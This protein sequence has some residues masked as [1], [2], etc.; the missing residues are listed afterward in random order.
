[1]H[2]IRLD[3]D[4][5]TCGKCTARVERALH[6][7]GIAQ[8]IE[9]ALD[10][11]HA[12]I[13]T[14][15]EHDATRAQLIEAIEDAGY[16]V[17]ERPEP[18]PQS[19]PMAPEERPSDQS[20]VQENQLD[21]SG[22]VVDV[23][24][25]TCASCV[26]RVERALSSLPQ[27]DHVAVNYATESA[28]LRW[29]PD[30]PFEPE[31]E[32]AIRDAVEGAG[33]SVHDVR[34]PHDTTRVASPSAEPPSR[35][36]PSARRAEEAARWRRRWV[37]GLVLTPAI[38][39]LQ[40]GPMMAD[41]SLGVAANAGRLVLCAYLT[42]VVAVAA[43]APFFVGAWRAARH[44]TATMDT[45]VALGAGV[46]Y[47]ASLVVTIA[48]IAGNVWALGAE[49][50]FDGAAMI[51]TLIGVG[52]WLEARA[53][54][55][56][57]H[58]IEALMQ[59]G[60]RRARVQRGD[61]WVEIDARE[62]RVGDILLVRPGETIPTD[63]VITQGRADVD[64]S[65][66]TGEPV[67]VA[68]EVGDEVAGATINTDGRL[69]VRAVRT[70]SDTLI[71]R[72]AREVERAQT[73]RAEI[74]R[75]ADR[76]SAI[77]V[78]AVLIASLVTFV[79]W[80]IATGV[81]SA[82]LLPAVAV[83]VV[84][85]PCAL[86]LATPTA[87]MV[88]TGRAAQQ[89]VLIRAASA[90]E[91][92]SRLDALV[93]DKTGTLTTG[94]MHVTDRIATTLEI[95]A[96]AMLQIVAS[97]EAHS[98]HPVAAAIATEAAE[99]GI[100]LLPITDFRA[101]AGHGVTATV[102]GAPI[103]IGKIEWM[104]E[105]AAID[106]DT[107][108][109]VRAL[110][111]QTRT[112]V[113]A[114]RAGQLIGIIATTDLVREGAREVITWLHDRHVQVWM[115]TGDAEATA[116]SVASALGIDPAHVRAGVAP[117]D[118]AAAVRGI[119]QG[120]Q[121][122]VAMVGDGINDA[123]ALAEADLGVAMGSGTDVAIEAADIALISPSLAGVTRAMALA[124]RTYATIRQNLFWAFVYNIVLIPVAASGWL[125]P[126]FAAAAMALSSVSVVTNSLR[127]RR[128]RLGALGESDSP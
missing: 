17:V 63:A 93:F 23:R 48:T 2:T 97:V 120:G 77:F 69:I 30:T 41:M 35:E 53:R 10:P 106:A 59:R 60:A 66:M 94:Q 100:S 124:Q 27:V 3:I 49:V 43:G 56:A 113:A 9:V 42:G 111:D 127:L 91:R 121:R 70:G 110:R 65:M 103:E 80:W 31:S 28:A 8:H 64:E 58:A 79:A 22:V 54:G 62:L 7:L 112:V 37:T 61:Q 6:E 125:R 88:G 21:T 109:R 19:P 39:A 123:P 46:A 119:Q 84:A 101:I 78:P 40:M 18:T 99:R 83:L 67:P 55:R 44:A 122:V 32:Q 89:G 52:K 34:R 25:M 105:R 90:L 72:I 4:G 87:L 57:S 116:M 85:C 115:I 29:R 13:T 33:Y 47:G 96:D 5:M 36:S 38:M 76:A 12:T 114:S 26:A 102:E 24:G 81:P 108:A 51:L 14:E 20:K 1:M 15:D 107:M 73:S 16:D 98:E 50:Y 117:R 75:L 128:T 74:Q 95:D 126:S 82:G 92:A 86:G 118:K 68:R 104:V 11:G 45:L 71:A